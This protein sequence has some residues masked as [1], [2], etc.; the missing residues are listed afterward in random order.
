MRSAIP[1]PPGDREAFPRGRGPRVRGFANE[2]IL[3]EGLSFCV[4]HTPEGAGECVTHKLV[5]R[6]ALPRGIGL[7][8]RGPLQSCEYKT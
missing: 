8:V 2:P 3:S 4:T 5:D 6:G 7:R 1:S